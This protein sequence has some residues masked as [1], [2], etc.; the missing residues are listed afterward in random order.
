MAI[1]SSSH[2]ITYKKE[3]SDVPLKLLLVTVA[4]IV[5]A[6]LVVHSG[7]RRHVPK[8]GAKKSLHKPGRAA[9][10]HAVGV[11]DAVVFERLKAQQ[12]RLVEKAP[13]NRFQVLRHGPHTATEGPHIH[14]GDYHLIRAEVKGTGVEFWTEGLTPDTK[15]K[16]SRVKD[17]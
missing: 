16:Y 15:G 17:A 13:I 1:R 12:D 6:D 7:D 11:S 14:I 10:L 9:D 2:T 4:E 3:V 8:G 5:G